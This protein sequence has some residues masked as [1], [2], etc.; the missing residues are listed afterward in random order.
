ML[1][2][3]I[4]QGQP[5]PRET[6]A[7]LFWDAK[8]TQQAQVALRV[9][10]QRVRQHVPDVES[11]RTQLRFAPSSQTTVDL[12]QLES[13]LQSGT[14]AQID[15]VLSLYNGPLLDNLYLDDAP[16]FNEWLQ[17]AR[18]QWR[19][20]IWSAYGELC[21]HYLKQKIWSAG[22][23]A[24]QRWLALDPLNEEAL[25]F[26]LRF[27][28]HNGQGEQAWQLYQ[29]SREQ[30]WDQLQ[31]E[32]EPE[33][34]HLAAAMRTLQPSQAISIAPL[35]SPTQNDEVKRFAGL[36]TNSIIPY[37]RNTEFV[38]RD[39]ILQEIAQ[40]LEHSAS[41]CTVIITGMAGI[42]K[43][44]LAVEFCYRYGRHFSGGC[45][46]LSFAGEETI[47]DEIVKIGGERGMGLYS[48]AEKLNHV[49]KV[50]RVCL[51][52]QAD[53]PR[54]L[55]FDNCESAELLTKWLPVTGGCRVLVTGRRGRW[56]SNIQLHL[57]PLTT[58]SPPES[59]KL[60][61][62][63]V[64]H[65]NIDIAEK[66]ATELEHL[67]LALYLA[68]RFLH[69]YQQVEPAQYLTQLRSGNLLQHPSLQGRGLANSPTGHE[70]HIA[71]TFAL[72][73]DQLDA[74]DEVDEM[75]LHMLAC[76][77]N[78]AHGEPIPQT[79][80][81]SCVLSNPTDFMQ[82]LLAVD[83]LNRLIDLGILRVEEEGTVQIHRLLAMYTQH[84]F[85]YQVAQAQTDVAQYIT[86]LLHE[87]YEK[88]RFL[89]H[90]PLDAVHLQTM[91]AQDN[92][93]GSRLAYLWAGHLRDIGDRKGA[94]AVLVTA[95]QQ[96][97]ARQNEADL[98][99]ALLFN[100]LG[101][102]T[103]ELGAQED[104]WSYFDEVLAIRRQ[105]VGEKHTLTAQSIQN[106]A[107][108][109]SRVG[110]LEQAN[111]ACLKA[112]DIYRSLEPPD[113]QQIGDTYY[114][115]AMN[116]RRAGELDQTI[117]YMQRSLETLK[118]IASEE[119]LYI[120]RALAALG[121]GHYMKGDYAQGTPLAQKSMA[122]PPKT[123]RGET[124]KDT[125]RFG[126]AGSN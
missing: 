96:K 57:H 88:T 6:I 21:Q 118:K 37:Q 62:R 11:S 93:F 38:G 75:A 5:Q 109:H 12:Y 29:F 104:A 67:P 32:P 24:A 39:G 42:G 114:S 30:L 64:S 81:N 120:A 16:R 119:S 3:L 73:L 105:V 97:K 10:I 122:N 99:L 83:G 98:L 90:L 15:H 35:N 9:T 113:H 112:I 44:Q 28:G 36:P 79:I 126:N 101:T 76:V 59:I 116:H 2:Y 121:Y 56:P 82:A 53:S 87:Q 61:K 100:F 68:G 22:V 86:D 26:A 18:E 20:R 13:A 23:K 92:D 69:R 52:W 91:A 17:I 55:V 78:F 80:L 60:L 111:A 115:L 89:G 46:W 74:Q 4:I 70:L 125:D 66:I 117:A 103:W 94:N 102:V 47:E 77:V 58:L 51:A 71:R 27:L 43:T 110:Q 84:Q 1:A 48:D 123:I 14:S 107:I 106:L 85:S 50:G 7:D 8:S 95:V 31:V 34:S 63:L 65:I 108:L 41:P 49:D 72:N 45:Y 33:T 19:Q 40:T 54:L 25:A 124:C